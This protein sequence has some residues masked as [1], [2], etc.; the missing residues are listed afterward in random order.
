MNLPMQTAL[1]PRT[2][3]YSAYSGAPIIVSCLIEHLFSQTVR[4]ETSLPEANHY[5]RT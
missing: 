5:L 4:R 3:N 1:Y 2:P